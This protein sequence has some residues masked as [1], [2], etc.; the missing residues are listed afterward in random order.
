MRDE[1]IIAEKQFQEAGPGDPEEAATVNRFLENILSPGDLKAFYQRTLD[2][3]WMIS[4]VLPESTALGVVYGPPGTYKSFL[5]IDMGASIATGTPWHGR[6]VKQRPVLYLAAE[7]G[8]GI[9][10]RAEAW[11]QHHGIEEWSGFYL[12]PM[13]C[14]ID[15]KGELALLLE[16]IRAL[17]ERPGVVFIDTLSKSMSG[18]ENQTPDMAR[19]VR[20]AN[21]ITEETG[22]I[23]VIVHHTGKDASRGARGSIALEGG[24]DT[25]FKVV[26]PDH[27]K[28]GL[29]CERQKDF[30]P[31]PDMAFDME[32]VFTGDT[33]AD[34]ES[35]TSL[36]PVYAPGG[37]V[38]ETKRPTLTGA[39]KTAWDALGTALADHGVAPSMEVREKMEMALPDDKVV[40]EDQWR[41]ISYK[42]GI[43]ST[44]DGQRKAFWKARNKLTTMGKVKTWDG[45]YWKP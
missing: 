28:A 14:L 18:D 6:E 38:Q 31:G 42:L 3:G 21:R 15:E 36:V 30:E 44:V 33:N 13:P 43:S 26:K 34:G 12:L 2:Q 8:G 10:K 7:A 1:L 16:T 27:L 41:E 9:A 23:V 24:C 17:P 32:V 35:I 29:I 40:H 5:A 39:T 11:R 45:Y 4:G 25:M 22:A 19:F 20:A 37:K